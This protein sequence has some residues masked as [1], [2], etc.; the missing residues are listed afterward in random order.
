MTDWAYIVLN[1]SGKLFVFVF[2]SSNAQNHTDP[3]NV[4]VINHGDVYLRKGKSSGNP[5]QKSVFPLASHYKSIYIFSKEIKPLMPHLVIM[6]YL[7][8]QTS[9]IITLGLS[10]SS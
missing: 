2:F 4:M 7:L 6:S 3:I 1:R 9:I 8:I 10:I 5:P